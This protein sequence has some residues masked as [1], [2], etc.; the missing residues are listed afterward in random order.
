VGSG[1]TLERALAAW[2]ARAPEVELRP[3]ELP[4]QADHATLET[5]LGALDPADATAFA[6]VDA[7]FLNFYRVEVMSLLRGR[8][9]AMPPLVEPGAIVADGVKLL[10]NTWVGAGAIIQPGCR[11]AFNVTIGAG[12]I[13]GGGAEIG[14]SAWIDAGVTI[15]HGAKIGSKATLGMG[16]VIGHGVEIGKLCVIDKPGRIEANVAD[17]TFIQSSHAHPMVIVGA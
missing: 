7:Y 14:Q 6:A 11:V 15:G 3:V 9:M 12:A 13:V 1:L 17:K 5:L 8:G 16:V 10:D 2:R 4:P